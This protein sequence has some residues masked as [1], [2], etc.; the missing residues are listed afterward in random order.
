MEVIIFK[1][2]S[3]DSTTTIDIYLSEHGYTVRHYNFRSITGRIKFDELIKD[4]VVEFPIIYIDE[5]VLIRPTIDELK[6]VIISKEDR[7]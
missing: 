2:C 3:C 5:T 4:V 1:K 7:L 6:N